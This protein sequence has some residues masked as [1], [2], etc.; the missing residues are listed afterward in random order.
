[1]GL[2][3]LPLAYRSRSMVC[4][5]C[6][7]LIDIV[8]Q[9]EPIRRLA[10]DPFVPQALRMKIVN[11]MFKGVKDCTEVTRRL[12][13]EAHASAAPWGGGGRGAKSLA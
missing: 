13:G 9:H 1:M 5:C 12:V 3:L 6:V 8:Q 4:F 2:R 11:E 7:Q 10:T